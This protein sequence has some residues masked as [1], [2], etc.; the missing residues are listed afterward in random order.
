MKKLVFTLIIC[1]LGYS[2][3]AQEREKAPG[4]SIPWELRKQAFIYNTAKIF[5]DATVQRVAL[6]NLMAENPGNVALYDSLAL[7]YL[8]YNQNA[9]AALVAQ[10][11]LEINPNDMFAVEIAAMGLDKL[12]AK[13]RSL[14][15]Y[16]KLY[17]NNGDI[18]TLYK[19]SFMQYELNRFA[20]ANTSLD[21]IIGNPESKEVEIGFPTANGQGQSVT[22]EVAAHR[23]K[24]MIE[25]AKGNT[26]EAKA[27]YLEVLE[28]K[29][30]FEIVQQQL[31]NLTKPEAGGE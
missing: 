3:F 27:K 30:G 5:N 23:V 4:D 19:I 7:I 6:Y 28:K 11:A 17:L 8:Q 10:Q 26:E 20:E 14:T 21:I 15:Y 9:S 25:E 16:E 24:A 12:G 22:L 31:R 2:S 18:N 13:D 29:P 1:G